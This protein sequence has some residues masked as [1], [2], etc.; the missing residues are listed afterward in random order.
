MNK[1]RISK[2]NNNHTLRG[3][4]LSFSPYEQTSNQS[5]SFKNAIKF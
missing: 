4:E 2:K 1:V 5:R 3:L